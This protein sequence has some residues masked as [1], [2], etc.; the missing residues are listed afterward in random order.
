[1]QLNSGLPACFAHRERCIYLLVDLFRVHVDGKYIMPLWLEQAIQIRSS[2]P[3]LCAAIDAISFILMG[4]FSRDETTTHSGLVQYTY[5]L[6]LAGA[7]ISDTQRRLG[8]DVFVAITLF[9]MIEVGLSDYLDFSCA[10][11]R[12]AR[13]TQ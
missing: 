8:D 11:N 13:C 2:S 10:T 7:A 1:M 4:K 9:G 6:Q 5:A 3:L 12:M